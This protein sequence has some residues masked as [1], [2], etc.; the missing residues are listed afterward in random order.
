MTHLLRKQNSGFTLIETLVAVTILM[1]AVAGPLVAAS[2][3]LNAALYSGDQMTASFLAQEAM[4]IIKNIRSN[5]VGI[6]T[7]VGSPPISECIGDGDLLHRCDIAFIPQYDENTVVLKRPCLA[8]GSCL[9]VSTSNGYAH[10]NEGNEG[11]RF[12]RYFYLEPLTTPADAYKVHVIVEWSQG[13]IP[14]QIELVSE[15]VNAII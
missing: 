3:S 13:R 2:R 1:I 11:K 5:N 14:Y 6:W 4:E 7:G 12:Y 9:L 15:L 8:D 10:D